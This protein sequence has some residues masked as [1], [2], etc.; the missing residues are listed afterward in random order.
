MMKKLNKE[1]VKDILG[2]LLFGISLFASLFLVSL[3]ENLM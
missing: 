1:T 2:G 3:V